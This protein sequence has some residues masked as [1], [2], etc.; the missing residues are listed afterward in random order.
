MIGLWRDVVDAIGVVIPVNDE[1][2]LL[3]RCLAALREALDELAVQRRYPP[4]V[5]VVLV[6]DDCTDGSAAIAAASGFE[7]LEVSARN[8]GMARCI[9]ASAVFAHVA[10]AGALSGAP[11]DA[12]HIWIANTDADSAVPRTWLTTQLALAE[13]GADLMVGTVRPDFADL[14]PA[15]TAVWLSTHVLGHAGGHVHGAN[16]G[17]RG[18]SYLAAGGFAALAEHEDVLLVE[19]LRAHPDTREVR[20]DACWVLTSG[21]MAGRTPGG[22]A[23]HLMS[24]LPPSNPLTADPDPTAEESITRV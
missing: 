13:E 3:P 7:V 11:T 18:D 16:L 23:Q 9:G 10:E 12:A 6:L 4:A 17:V 19:S 15:Q 8:V 21:R 2:G 5:Y 24:T 1:E 20:T 14:T 22:Y